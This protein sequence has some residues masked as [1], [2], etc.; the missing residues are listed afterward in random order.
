MRT[1][2]LSIAALGHYTLAVGQT[3]CPP[4]WCP[5]GESFSLSASVNALAVFDAGAGPRLYA[6]G[7]FVSIEFQTAQHL[8]VWDGLAWT[9]VLPGATA[10][11]VPGFGTSIRV[12]KVLDDG[13]GP[14][15]FVGGQF[16]SIGGIDAM[17]VA[18]FDGTLWSSVAEGLEA[19]SPAPGFTTV[20]D[21]AVFDSGQ[22]PEL[23]VG[24]FF[25]LASQPSTGGVAKRTNGVWSVVADGIGSD[26]G[27]PVGVGALRVFDDG[28]GEALFVSGSFR[29]AGGQPAR[30]IARWDGT[31][32][33]G[34]GAGI[35]E[36]PPMLYVPTVT[37]LLPSTQN[38]SSVL[39]AA[40]DFI[41]NGAH[42]LAAWDGAAWAGGLGDFLPDG[43]IS[44]ADIDT[45]TGPVLYVGGNFT[46]VD[47]ASNPHLVRRNDAGWESLGLLPCQ[48][49]SRVTRLIRF[50][51]DGGPAVFVGGRDIRPTGQSECMPVG[52]LGIVQGD[53]DC[54]QDVDLQDLALLLGAYGESSAG[55]VN[56]DGA[57]TL[58]DL[59]ILLAQ[60]GS[61]CD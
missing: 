3:P 30:N 18:R 32:W 61:V 52:R 7:S 42:G 50:A 47:G 15:L 45:G 37:D 9:R 58:A 33:S 39:L 38:G 20:Y 4:Q 22:G 54:D 60:F 11:A 13:S 5:I 28:S 40:G 10:A 25:R 55:D 59:S 49:Q 36:A 1:L 27:Q 24:G 48:N 8:A 23:Y 14:A 21:L 2:A 56:G 51:A 29:Y 34:V 46:S 26:S 12:I 44:L 43:T 17:M 53:L 41:V 35:E 31:T 16:R 6:G 19:Y 57:T